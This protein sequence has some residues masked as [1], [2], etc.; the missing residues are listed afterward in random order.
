[1]NVN[2]AINLVQEKCRKGFHGE[3]ISFNSF[4]YYICAGDCFIC[5]VKTF[6]RF[7][8][9]VEKKQ[10]EIEI[11]DFEMPT[12]LSCWCF[13]CQAMKIANRYINN[14]VYFCNDCGKG[15]FYIEN[16]ET[17]DKEKLLIKEEADEIQKKLR[18]EQ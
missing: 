7:L 14:N 3:A 10:N 13:Q 4:D 9:E 2:E 16:P 6:I 5:G 17:F 18:G 11:I 1:M 15:I 8:K 12:T